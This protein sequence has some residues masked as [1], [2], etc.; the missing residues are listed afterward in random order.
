MFTLLEFA[1]TGLTSF[2]AR[3]SRAADDSSS[4]T[5]VSAPPV[6]TTGGS[7]DPREGADWSEG[8][9]RG[10]VRLELKWRPDVD[11]TCFEVVNIVN[12]FD[13]LESLAV[14]AHDPQ[15]SGR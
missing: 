3:G 8:R 6:T 13:S 10:G 2:V 1:G 4:Q 14:S 5:D 7:R 9:G 11:P 15:V 12:S